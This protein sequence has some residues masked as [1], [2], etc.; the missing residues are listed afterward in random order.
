MARAWIGAERLAGHRCRNR[1][2]DKFA[3]GVWLTVLDGKDRIKSRGTR[4]SGGSD[5]EPA[6]GPCCKWPRRS[7]KAQGWWT[8][9]DV[10]WRKAWAARWKI[11]SH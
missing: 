6:S 10:T 5:V 2:L 11:S 9:A 8:A 1:S 3:S 7:A 4:S